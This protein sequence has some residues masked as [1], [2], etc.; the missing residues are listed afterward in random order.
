MTIWG[1]PAPGTLPAVLAGGGH[2]GGRRRPRPGW[3]RPGTCGPARP[4]LDV[5]HHPHRRPG[6]SATWTRR[7]REVAGFPRPGA[8]RDR[9]DDPGHAADQRGRG[10]PS[11]VTAVRVAMHV[12]Q[13]TVPPE[14][15]RE[16]VDRQFPQWR[17][18]PVRRVRSPRGRSTRSSGSATGSPPVFRCSPATWRR[19][20]SGLE[21]EAS[22]ARRLLGRTRF[23]VP[24]PVAVGEPGAGYPLP[25]SVQTWLPGSTATEQDPGE[26]AGFAHDLAELIGGIRAIGTGGR[27]VRRDRSRR[28]PGVPRQGGSGD[29]LPAQRAAARRAPAAPA[30]AGA[31]ASCRA[32]VP[33]VM[34]HG[35]LIPGN[36]LS[37]RRAGSPASSTSAGLGPADPALDLVE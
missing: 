12:D 23:P 27:D 14:T 6:W 3:S 25:W 11:G 19:R 28:R 24:E 20:G 30:L 36:V 13:L 1:T 29:L 35:D 21:S 33:D 2:R 10:P 8:R 31:C 32:T 4:V 9:A 26:S 15:V 34:T 18:L 16:L 7:S 5:G 37:V 17:P 22:A